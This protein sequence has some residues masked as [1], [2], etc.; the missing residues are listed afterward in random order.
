MKIVVM[1]T[2]PFAVPMFEALCDS[3]EHEVVAVITRPDRQGKSRQA[4]VNPMRAAAERRGLPIH[5]PEDINAEEGQQ[6]LDRLGP[7]VLVV[8]DYGRILSRDILGKAPLG[9]V[10]LHGSLLPRYRGAAP[11]QWALLNGDRETGVTVIHMTPRMDAGPILAVERLA[12]GDDETHEQLEPRLAA[13][14]AEPVLRSLQML[15]EWDGESPIGEPQD[16][17]QASKAPRLA[18]ADGRIDWTANSA[19]I[20]NRVR[21]LQ[22]WPGAF[23]FIQRGKGGPQRLLLIRLRPLLPEERDIEVSDARLSEAEPGEVILSDRKRLWI[24]TGEGAVALETIQPAG[25]RTMEIEE[26]LRGFQPALGSKLDPAA[27]KPS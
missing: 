1:G 19:A 11:V 24:R 2:G 10:N 27:E 6:L 12:I 26:F 20:H 25:K 18:K 7:E 13:L 3:T 17:A 9:G 14:G 15:A 8:C 4:V 21:A 5:A 22:P 16:P 23:T